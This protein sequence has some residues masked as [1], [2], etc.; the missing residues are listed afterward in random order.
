MISESNQCGVYAHIPYC[1][2]VCPYCDFAK[3]ANFS[4]EVVKRYWQVLTEQLK[5]LLNAEAASSYHKAGLASVFFGGGTPG[6]FGDE[7]APVMELLRPFLQMNAEVSLEANPDDL[8]PERIALWRDLGFNRLSVGVQTFDPNGLKVLGRQHDASQASSRIAGALTLM[9]NL[10]VDLIYGWPGQSLQSWRQD[11][12]HVIGLGVPHLSLYCLTFER[13]TPLGRKAQRGLILPP[14]DSALVNAYETA[15]QVLARAGYQHEEVSNWA[16]PG[17][18]CVHNWL[19][20][21]DQSF[22]GVGAGAHGYFARDVGPGVRYAFG[23]NDRTFIRQQPVAFTNAC[24]LEQLMTKLGAELDQDRDM[25]I[26]FLELLGAGLRTKRGINLLGALQ[27]CEKLWRPSPMV[28]EALDRGL[29]SIT[30]EGRLILAPK[31]WFRE[32]GWASEI[33]RSV[34]AQRSD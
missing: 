21:S 18:S 11:L 5:V 23:G 16:K 17:A 7:F 33:S 9:P 27:R 28:Q 31:E 14:E 19:Y 24:D 6:L 26:W 10:N 4:V 20:W 1:S 32:V 22:I 3:T 2:A 34:V 25:E 8:L 29:M 12:D 13:R 15:C 30:A